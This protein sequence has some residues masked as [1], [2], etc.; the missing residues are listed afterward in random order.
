MPHHYTS[1]TYADASTQ[2]DSACKWL[3]SIGINF[4]PTRV[5]KYR[6]IFAAVAK[7]QQSKTVS[8]FLE[9]NK[10]EEWVNA[11]HEVAEISR[12]FEGL[13]TQDNAN[14]IQRL[15]RALK[16]HD[17]YVLEDNDS[18]GRD[19]S[20]E[21]SV[22]AKFVRSGYA[23]DFGHD[24]DIAVDMKPF[25]FYAECKRLKSKLQIEKRIAEGLQQLVTRYEASPNP[26]QAR[27]ILVLS[28]GKT[29]NSDLGLLVANSSEA[30]ADAA[31]RHNAAFIAQYKSSWQMGVDH[32]TLGVAIILDAPGII[33]SENKLVTCHEITMNNSVPVETENHALLFRVAH[34]VFG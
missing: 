20:F 2:L 28:I 14:L 33:E 15:K 10:F 25:S 17:R 3:Q 18:S 7:H 1:K 12:I 6:K 30:L 19:F 34:Q 9:G 8:A 31:F 26:T 29:V 22:A 27:G 21:L 32:R 5:G 13:S 11:A 16:G 4:S 23:V 24:A